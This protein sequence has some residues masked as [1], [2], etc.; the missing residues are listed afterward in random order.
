MLEQTLKQKAI[1]GSIWKFFELFCSQGINLL[2][3]CILA[4]LLTPTQFG[5]V[6]LLY[7]FT[8]ITIPLAQGALASA[9]VQK[10]DVTKLDQN[11]AF[12]FNIGTSFI[13]YV[14]LFSI[15][16]FVAK[17]YDIPELSAIMKVFSLSIILLSICDVPH[18]ILVKQLSFNYQFRVGL[19]QTIVHGVVGITM[20]LTNFGVWA[21]VI[22]TLAGQFI[23]LI[24]KFY[25]AKWLPGFTFSF[26]SLWPLFQYG[27]KLTFSGIL[28]QLMLNIR[29]LVIGK[30][31]SREDLSISSKGT[32]IPSFAMNLLNS[33]ITGVSFPVL[34]HLQD[35][36]PE[37]ISTMRKMIQYSCFVV[38]PT[39]SLMAINAE[40][41]VR[42][43]LGEQWLAAVP[44]LQIACISY[45]LHPF[46]T[47]NLQAMNALGRSDM[48]LKL[49]IIKEA[50][51][52]TI[53]LLTYKHGVF[54]MI[55]AGY[56]MGPI[57]IFI[58]SYPNAKLL[59][60]TAIMQIKDVI[61]TIIACSLGFIPFIF[62]HSINKANIVM[63]IIS[64]FIFI[65]LFV[66]YSLRLKTPAFVFYYN[67]L[68]T[69]LKLKKIDETK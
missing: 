15:S 7:I 42:I 53:L 28:G 29:G 36:K 25:Y 58:N 59:G 23:A 64:S 35:N 56:L 54:T 17:Y 30:V 8:A 67:L 19:S 20:A 38:M 37:F 50:L 60:Y 9:L 44:F 1:R 26:K 10:K 6:A 5:T 39:M 27:W 4:R 46:H 14:I 21:L 57:A 65:C 13:I 18:S 12:W 2:V 41:I 32:Q 45:A 31:Y 66:L 69:K 11:S 48:Y 34:S 24:L 47:I 33:S 49:Q 3:G 62:L 16:P 52:L 40:I 51:N 68:C 61:H 22:S 55:A 43:M 63:C